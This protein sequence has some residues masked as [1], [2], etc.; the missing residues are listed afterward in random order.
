MVRTEYL[1]LNY[2]PSVWVAEHTVEAMAL[3]R[4]ASGS[5]LITSRLRRRFI[6]D[7]SSLEEGRDR[8]EG[9]DENDQAAQGAQS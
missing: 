8:R 2:G 1:A 5:L 7:A 3:L 4:S 9:H 6:S